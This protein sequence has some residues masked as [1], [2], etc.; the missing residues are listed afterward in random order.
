MPWVTHLRVRP[1]LEHEPLD[2][3]RVVGT[4]QVVADQGGYRGQEA[5]DLL[6]AQVPVVVTQTCPLPEPAGQVSSASPPETGR[7]ARWSVHAAMKSP[8]H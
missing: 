3:L 5:V 6:D 8:Q 2:W 4:V 7:T 1:T